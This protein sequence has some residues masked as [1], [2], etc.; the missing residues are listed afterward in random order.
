MN[1][2]TLLAFTLFL[3]VVLHSC[4]GEAD[5][6]SQKA[7]VSAPSVS[8]QFLNISDV[9]FNPFYDSTLVPQLA[10]SDV[11]DWQ[12]IFESSS[13]T[14]LSSYTNGRHDA[15]YPLLVSALEAMQASSPNPDFIIVP[16]DFLSHNFEDDFYS[17]SGVDQHKD[18]TEGYPQLHSFIDKTM[19][20]LAMMIDKG[21][22]STP[23]IAALGNNDAY[24]GDYMIQPGSSFLSMMA[25]LWKPL[26][27]TNN[28]G[29][30]DKTF[31]EG[32]YYSIPSPVDSNLLIVVLNTIYMS[33]NFNKR[34]PCYCVPGDFGPDN[35]GPGKTELAWL[36]KQLSSAR[37]AG[38]KVWIVQHIP[39]GM[40]TY[41]AAKGTPGYDY[42]PQFNEEYLKVIR[43]NTDVIA[44]NIAG[45]Y[46]MDDFR[47]MRDSAGTAWSYIHLVPS[48]SPY[49][50]NNPGFE[51]VEYSAESDELL[52]Y[53]ATYANVANEPGLHQVTWNTEYRFSDLYN[54]KK[55]T[56]ATLDNVWTK[57]ATDTALQNRYMLYYPVSNVDAFNS[58]RAKFKAFWCSIGNATLEAYLS[59]H[60]GS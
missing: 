21:W 49:N 39:P 12:R 40:D 28:T 41:E 52:D 36:E 31:T 14:L 10:A 57:L 27:R 30:F 32:G 60:E 22:P 29:T 44:A 24:C 59:C 25:K 58:N 43:A 18:S 48:I 34:T 47:L 35:A 8:G 2:R 26:L 9:H 56:A 5:T 11:A 13:D 4:G 17:F 54:E 16:G 55:I 19:S 45:H 51:I 38:Q 7:D 50:G 15:D 37:D 3:A 20:F 33:K 53:R 23:M 42:T 46:H 1:Q 6:P